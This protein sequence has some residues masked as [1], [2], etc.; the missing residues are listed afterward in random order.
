MLKTFRYRLVPTRKQEIAL[1][2]TLDLCCN[3]YNCALEQ[4]RMHRTGYYEQKRQVTD[5]RAEFPEY[6]GV[7]V[8]VLQRVIAKLDLAF[9]SFFRRVKAG[10]KPGF[11][12]FKGRDRF[13]S[14]AFNNTGFKL[15]GRYLQISKIGAVKLRLSRSLPKDAVIKSLI[16]K[17]SGQNWH[18]CLAV[19]YTPATLPANASAIGLDMGIENFAALSDG[20]FIP[21]PRLY[22]SAQA[23]LRVAQRRVA[24]RKKGSHRRCKAVQMLRKIHQKVA[25]R[26][27]DFLHKA[28]TQLVRQYGTIVIESLN[29]KGLVQG[30]LSKQV[31]DAGWAS[32]RQMLAYKA[33]EAGR[34]LFEV[35]CAYTSQTCPKCGVIKKKALSE[36]RHDCECGYSTHRDTAAALVI[37]GRICPLGANV[38]EPISCVA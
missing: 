19:E 34:K 30:I 22:E 1:Q 16:V 20:T 27:N 26:R 11:P 33:E 8:H 32:F 23:E 4:R 12:R 7:H 15:A 38:E 36:R 6:Q 5:V 10:Q 24:R 18:A 13:D 29:V 14:F 31:L 2:N 25:N 35:D 17:R 21:N 37:L 9:Q 3:L 28:T